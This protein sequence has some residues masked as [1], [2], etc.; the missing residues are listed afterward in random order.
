M[1]MDESHF[2]ELFRQRQTWFIKLLVEGTL[3]LLETVTSVRI[4]ALQMAMGHSTVLRKESGDNEVSIVTHI[5]M[6]RG[7]TK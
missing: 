4:A 2:I 6:T 3:I 1:K 5:L 7:K